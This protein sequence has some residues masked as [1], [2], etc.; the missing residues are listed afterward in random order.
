MSD[1]ID[2]DTRQLMQLASR[3]RGA[4]RIVGEELVRAG[5]RSILA[6]E[7]TSKQI[8]ASERRDLGNLVRSITGEVRPVAG[9]LQLIAGSNA[10]YAEVVHEGRGAN[11]PMPPQGV[12]LPWMR[13]HGIPDSAE[14]VLRRKIGRDGIPGIF[15]F[16]R[17]FAQQRAAIGREFAQV[18]ARVMA[19]MR[20]SQR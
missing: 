12:L 14:F 19:R 4:D 16:K 11:K 2:V 6:V 17:A 18:P 20:S 13:R 10:P 5:Q 3:M 1:R 15:F 9:G 7:Q 8:V